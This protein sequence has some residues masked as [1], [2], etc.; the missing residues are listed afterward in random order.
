MAR[1]TL[2]AAQDLN[3]AIGREN[4]IPWHVPE[5]FAFFKQ[6]T[7]G[8]AVLMGRKTWDSLPRKPLPGRLNV[9]MTRQPRTPQP[10]TVFCSLD[11]AVGVAREAGYQRIYCIG[12]SQIY[13]QMLPM[14]DR[15]LLSTVETRVENP[16]A[17][18]PLLDPDA[19]DIVD[20]RL[21]RASHPICRLTEFR[22]SGVA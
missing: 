6:E 5:D 10:G 16:D 20:E 8:G 15:I 22:R 2:I 9:V 13:G 14:A 3:R 17:F 1:L 12:G 19:W 4:T 21:L 11:D 7:T 18:F